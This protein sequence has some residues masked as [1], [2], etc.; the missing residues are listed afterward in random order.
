MRTDQNRHSRP[1]VP[2][3]VHLRFGILRMIS[4]N[5]RPRAEVLSTE[6]VPDFVTKITEDTIM[7]TH[8]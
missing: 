6:E 3:S 7:K 4:L 5:M 1:S 2:N 8:P